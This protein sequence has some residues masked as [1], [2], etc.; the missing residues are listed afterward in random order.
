MINAVIIEDETPLRTLI[1]KLVKEVDPLI[2]IIQECEDYSSALAVLSKSSA[3]IIFLDINLPGGSGLDL[4]KALPDLNSEVI[5]ITAYNEYV[6]SAFE[7]SAVGFI[8]KPIDK[9]KLEIAINN[10]KRR[11]KEKT[12]NNINELLKYI[13]TNSNTQKIGIPTQEGLTFVNTSDIIRCEGY[14]SY[15]KL[16]FKDGSEILSSYNL[17]RFQNILPENDFFKVHKS[18]IVAISFIEKYHSKD[19][20]IVMNNGAE[21]PISKKVKVDFMQLFKTPKR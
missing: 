21:V 20:I 14:N 8:L 17:S 1:K 16:H 18:H 11:I 2:N 6:L 3:D 19:S 7:H 12:N 9:N 4:L 15:T 13:E 10:A 5:F